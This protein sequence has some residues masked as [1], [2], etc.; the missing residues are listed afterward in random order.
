M[1]HSDVIDVA[2]FEQ[3]MTKE[4][5][6][7]ETLHWHRQDPEWTCGERGGLGDKGGHVRCDSHGAQN[8][9]LFCALAYFFEHSAHDALL[10]EFP[11]PKE[12][13]GTPQSLEELKK[14]PSKF[15]D[16]SFYLR[17]LAILVGDLHQPLHWLHEHSYGKD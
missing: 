13:I 1:M 2:S 15:Q 6:A 4:H 16:K 9:S 8:G 14:V 12:P 17:W 11:E 5:P 3:L 10:Q 7:T